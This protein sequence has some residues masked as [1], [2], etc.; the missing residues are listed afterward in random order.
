MKTIAGYMLIASIMF[1]VGSFAVV[2]KN[3]HG[4]LTQVTHY[5]TGMF[6]KSGEIYR[7]YAYNCAVPEGMMDKWYRVEFNSRVVYVWAND[8]CKQGFDLTPSA[9]KMLAPLERGTI[10]C[11]VEEAK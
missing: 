1:L 9:F 3:W 2:I 4:S 8:S 10:S 5:D 7:A 6:T 11:K